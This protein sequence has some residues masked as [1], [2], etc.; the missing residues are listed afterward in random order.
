MIIL[1]RAILKQSKIFVLDEATA[2]VDLKTDY[3]IKRTLRD[4]LKGRTA[5]MVA[6]R[7]PTVIESDKM[8]V[9]NHGRVEEFDHPFKLMAINCLL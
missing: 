9:M 3:F 4:V 5:F 6:H 8:L 1:T 7:I 2:N